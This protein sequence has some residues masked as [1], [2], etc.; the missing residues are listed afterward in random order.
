MRSVRERADCGQND[1]E[2]FAEVSAHAAEVHGLTDIP[3]ELVDQVRANIRS[4]G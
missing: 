3:T 1:D 4:V 2:I